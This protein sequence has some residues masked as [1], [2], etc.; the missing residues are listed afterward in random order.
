MGRALR[1]NGSLPNRFVPFF[2]TLPR[3][4]LVIQSGW[5]Q[6]AMPDGGLQEICDIFELVV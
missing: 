5:Y 1:I 4:G 2:T 6:A 3:N